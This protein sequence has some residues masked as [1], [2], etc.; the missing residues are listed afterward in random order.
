MTQ[1]T[2]GGL[3]MPRKSRVTTGSMV[4]L[5]LAL[6]V[7]A[8]TFALGGNAERLIANRAIDTL[9]PDLRRFFDTNREFILRHTTDSLTLLERNPKTELQNHVLFLDHYGK[10]PFETLPR[11]YKNAVAK[12]SRQKLETAGVLP[13]QIGVYSQRLTEAMRAGN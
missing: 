8:R 1:I 7:P 11:S 9:P 4:I 6:L 2:M 10:F 3:L 5:V 12:F 13:W